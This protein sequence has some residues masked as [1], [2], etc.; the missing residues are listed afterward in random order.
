MLSV[1]VETD[2]ITKFDLQIFEGE[3]MRRIIDV[4][5]RSLCVQKSTENS[6][7]NLWLKQKLDYITLVK[8]AKIIV[9]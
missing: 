9:N 6:C 3:F 1:E 4:S 5:I 7:V 2:L 8:H